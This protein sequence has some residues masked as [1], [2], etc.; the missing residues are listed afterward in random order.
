MA[1]DTFA[2][3]TSFR[4]WTCAAIG[5]LLLAGCES[6]D[7]PAVSAVQDPIIRDIP[8]PAGFALNDKNSRATFSGATRVA[9]VQYTG[10]MERT[11][12]K[13]FY[14][15]YMPSAGFSLKHGSLNAGVFSLSFES[16]KEICVVR[17]GPSGLKTVLDV[18]LMPRPDNAVAREAPPAEGRPRGG[19]KP[20]TAA[21]RATPP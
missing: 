13:Q 10:S 5:V 11:K 16:D 9:Q 18:D 1:A 4:I 17:I 15:E 12:V 6:N 7:G 8:K 3:V 2:S 21:D 19:N 20:R 14:E